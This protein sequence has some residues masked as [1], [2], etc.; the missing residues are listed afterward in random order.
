MLFHELFGQNSFDIHRVYIVR[1]IGLIDIHNQYQHFAILALTNW[2]G[3]T[4]YKQL[5]SSARSKMQ[6][7]CQSIVWKI[8]PEIGYEHMNTYARKIW[9]F[10]GKKMEASLVNLNCIVEIYL[11]TKLHRKLKN[12]SQR[13]GVQLLDLLCT[14]FKKSQEIRDGLVN[15]PHAKW[16]HKGSVKKIFGVSTRRVFT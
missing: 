13:H 2:K 8:E 5:H 7:K 10:L 16:R 11:T 12:I 9:I 15:R 4:W 6:K 3:K 1:N 14:I